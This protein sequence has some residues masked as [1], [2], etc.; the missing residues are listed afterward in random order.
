MLINWAKVI[1]ACVALV[2]ITVM[3]TAGSMQEVAAA[4]LFGTIFGYSLGNGI[5]VTKGQ[6]IPGIMRPKPGGRRA[7]DDDGTP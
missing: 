1:V 6:D 7:D 5:N 2:C 3:V 4:G